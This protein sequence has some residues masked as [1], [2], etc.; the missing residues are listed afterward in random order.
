[1]KRSIIY[2]AVLSAMLMVTGCGGGDN[3]SEQGKNNP[4]VNH[5]DTGLSEAQKA[6]ILNVA[7][8]TGV[9]SLKESLLSGVVDTLVYGTDE[10]DEDRECTS[11]SYSKVGD[12]IT[13]NNCKGLYHTATGLNESQDLTVNGQVTITT[14]SYQYQN[15]IL[16]AANGESKT[17]N[18]TLKLVDT[19]TTSTVSTDS[20]KVEATEKQGTASAEVDYTLTD[21]KLTYTK[22]SATEV[23]L[24]TQGS[25]S[26]T[27]SSVGDY[28][29]KFET[30]TPFLVQFDAKED[31]ISSYPYAGMLKVTNTSYGS[32][33]TLTSNNDKKTVQYT[34]TAQNKTLASGT[35]TWGEVLGDQHNATGRKDNLGE[36]NSSEMNGNTGNNNTPIDVGRYLYSIDNDSNTQGS[37]GE[38]CEGVRNKFKDT[39]AYYAKADI[40]LDATDCDC[41]YY[42]HSK[43]FPGSAPQ[44]LKW[45]CTIH[46]NLIDKPS[47]WNGSR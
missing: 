4:P 3:D 18:G 46:Y 36:N 16:V 6:K 5:P 24:N 15:L 8:E 28:S 27:N 37:Q 23:A 7:E 38:A 11:G 45:F 14:D 39:K 30:T 12:V 33:T 47:N 31:E 9:I 26:V 41:K 40:Q 2:T 17:V 35:K 25:L 19:A 22:N 32:T 20:L 13:F 42:D 43:V 21:Y 10:V 29:I 44:P 1:M 34:V